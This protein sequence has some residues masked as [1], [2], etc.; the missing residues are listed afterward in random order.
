MFNV[1]VPP[2]GTQLD[3]APKLDANLRVQ[4]VLGQVQ[5]AAVGSS[6]RVVEATLASVVAFVEGLGLAVEPLTINKA[7]SSVATAIS[8]RARLGTR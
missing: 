6:R 7:S 5:F 3:E 2:F 4:A 8:P 1:H